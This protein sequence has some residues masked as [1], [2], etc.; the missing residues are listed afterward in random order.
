MKK[1]LMKLLP[2]V[3]FLSL[4][5]VPAS[6]QQLKIA[7]VDLSKVFTNY[8]KTK[9]ADA[10]LQDMK[11]EMAK[12]DKEMIDGWQKAKDTYQKLLADANNQ[13]LSSEQRDKNKK[14]AED[15]LK[16]MK[17]TENNIQQFETQAKA[18]LQEQTFR[19][20]EN[21]LSEIRVAINQ[22]AKS[23]NYTFIVDTAAQSADR[24]PVFLY[25][26]AEDLTDAVVSHL[27]A[28]A[29]VEPVSKDKDKEKDKDK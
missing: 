21:L 26:S 9:Q 4:M 16:E 12:S 24:T 22:K 7:T 28:G 13:I 8:Y 23:G 19:M 25:S 1:L 27:N 18:R 15:K 6:A 11:T 10:A 2:A 17:D 3:L 29:P 20:R 14:S 5:S